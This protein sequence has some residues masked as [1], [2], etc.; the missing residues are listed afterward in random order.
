MIEGQR[1]SNA[2]EVDK[3]EG[4]PGLKKKELKKRK[5]GNKKS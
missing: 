5:V 3:G 2:G 1:D 4:I